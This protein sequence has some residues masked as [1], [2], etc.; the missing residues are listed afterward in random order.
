MTLPRVRWNRWW[1]F[2]SCLTWL[3]IW[4][5]IKNMAKAC[6]KFIRLSSQFVFGL[7]FLF[8]LLLLSSLAPTLSALSKP[9]IQAHRDLNGNECV[10]ND[11]II[12]YF[13]RNNE[14][15]LHALKMVIKHCLDGGN[16][17]ERWNTKKQ[18]RK[19][20]TKS[21]SVKSNSSCSNKIND[22]G[23]S[24]IFLMVAFVHFFFM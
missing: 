14:I 23:V 18:R 15:M 8:F 16:T 24:H 3:T 10:C 22:N 12:N 2:E 13:G 21:R 4:D 11:F 7:C 6:Y 20:N 9:A 17:R 5:I 19:K 1:N